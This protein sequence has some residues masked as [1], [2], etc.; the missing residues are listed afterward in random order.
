MT[1]SSPDFLS[2]HDLPAIE[3]FAAPMVPKL[4]MVPRQ[5]GSPDANL[6]TPVA[7]MFYDKRAAIRS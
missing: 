7:H 6:P 2:L 5:M 1:A 3:T 4:I